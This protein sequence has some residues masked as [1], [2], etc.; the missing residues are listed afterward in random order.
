MGF[1][2][3]AGPRRGVVASS[4]RGCWCRAARRR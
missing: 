1:L 2:R 3:P 4:P